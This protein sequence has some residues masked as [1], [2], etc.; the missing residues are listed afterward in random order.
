[1]QELQTKEA[2]PHVENI[3]GALRELIEH[4]R[5]DA[6]IVEEERAAALFEM[7]AEVLDGLVHA[8]EHFGEETRSAAV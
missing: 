8:Y 7:S 3:K 6:T 4:L 2:G 1:M 5:R